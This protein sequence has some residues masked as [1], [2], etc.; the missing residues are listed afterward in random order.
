[1]LVKRVLP[2]FIEY[3]FLIQLF[4]KSF[5][6]PVI[7]AHC[8]GLKTQANS[9]YFDVEFRSFLRSVFQ[10]AFLDKGYD[11][12]REELRKTK[13]FFEIFGPLFSTI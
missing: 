7:E 8:C 11:L 2:D 12:I 1:M 3:F 4:S 6:P 9:L 13:F 10:R 5:S